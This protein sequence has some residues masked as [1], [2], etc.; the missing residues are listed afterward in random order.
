MFQCRGF[1]WQSRSPPPHYSPSYPALPLFSMCSTLPLFPSVSPPHSINP[2]LNAVASQNHSPTHSVFIIASPQCHQLSI[3]SI[4]S[5]Q[6]IQSFNHVQLKLVVK[7]NKEASVQQAQYS[8][9]CPSSHCYYLSI[10]SL[11]TPRCVSSGGPRRRTLPDGPDKP[12]EE[13][14][15]LRCYNA[16]AHEYRYV[17]Y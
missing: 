15:R 7:L 9:S 3:V 13:V 17:S 12:G 14:C 2:P 6:I 11:F 5:W 8:C 10:P 4:R 16:G 1:L